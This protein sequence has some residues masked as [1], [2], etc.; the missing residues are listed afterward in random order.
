M[1]TTKTKT[2]IYYVVFVGTIEGLEKKYIQYTNSAE[3][4]KKIMQIIIKMKT[5]GLK[6]YQFFIED[7]YLDSVWS[8]QKEKIP[9]NT[10]HGRLFTQV[11]NLVNT[12]NKNLSNVLR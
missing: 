7:L 9:F 1:F 3:E 2:K 4:A 5:L 10:L 8:D 11:D 12:I 6:N